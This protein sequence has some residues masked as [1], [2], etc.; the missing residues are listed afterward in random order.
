MSIPFERPFTITRSGIG[1]YGADGEWVPGVDS[2][3]TLMATVLPPT[4]KE[5]HALEARFMAAGSR[6]TGIMNIYST[7]YIRS[8]DEAASV[9]GDRFVF[10]TKTYEVVEVNHYRDVLPHYKGVAII[11]GNKEP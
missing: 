10:E 9:I 7:S 2:E 6:T 3:L 8:A 5:K 4:G 1:E 11:V